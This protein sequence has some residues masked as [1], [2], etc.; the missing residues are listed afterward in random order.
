MRWWEFPYFIVLMLILAVVVC[1][2]RSFHS[3]FY[4]P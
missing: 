2:K 3:I 1:F 4:G